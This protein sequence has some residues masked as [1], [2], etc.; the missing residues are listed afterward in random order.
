M[1]AAQ[2]GA[3]FRAQQR[4]ARSAQHY[5]AGRK[6]S[7]PLERRAAR[8]ERPALLLASRARRTTT[9]AA[10]LEALPQI[11][12]KLSRKVRGDPALA[13]GVERAAV[14]GQFHRELALAQE[15]RQPHVEQAV[16]I[17]ML[18]KIAPS[19][20]DAGRARSER[21]REKSVNVT[22]RRNE[23]VEQRRL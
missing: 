1:G 10:E 14:I 16:R 8:D 6:H 19:L 11:F 5:D 12:R 9:A 4:S 21:D 2:C 20:R 13:R 3:L 18:V 23:K 15:L 17:A 22:R 7:I